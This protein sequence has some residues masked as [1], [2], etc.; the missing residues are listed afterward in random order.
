MKKTEGTVITVGPGKPHQESGILYPMPVAAGDSVIYGQY[1]GT[2]FEMNGETHALIRDD[3]ILIKFTG[4]K[5]SLESVEVVNDYVLVYV[6]TQG[7][8]KT[9]SGGL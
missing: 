6:F 8:E 3:D 1:D 7:E 9:T 4:D 5:L 2:K